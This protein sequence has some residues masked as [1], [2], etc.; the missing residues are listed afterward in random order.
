MSKPPSGGRIRY[1]Q[2]TD[3]GR[4]TAGQKTRKMHGSMHVSGT[5]A[6]EKKA[7]GGSGGEMASIALM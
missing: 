5:I 7:I 2:H 4:I 6:G 3:D 1:E